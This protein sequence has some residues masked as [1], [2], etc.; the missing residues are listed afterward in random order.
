MGN[1]ERELYSV[2]EVAELLG[3]HVRTVRN[4]VRDGRL[5]AVRIG[6]QYRVS[7]DDLAALTHRSAGGT[8]PAATPAPGRVEVSGIVQIDALG[9][10]AAHRLMTF[11][12]AGAQSARDTPDPLRVQTFYDE[13]RSRMKIVVL[14]GAAATADLLHMIEDLLDPD[15]GLF[16]SARSSSTGGQAADRA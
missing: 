3:L 10:D 8:A 16:A 15:S 5:R 4:Y 14:G 13:E 2:G 12:T 1:D 11:A 7:K 6:R 9:P